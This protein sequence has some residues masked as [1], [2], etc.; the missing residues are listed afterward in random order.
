[1]TSTQQP[2]ELSE[3]ELRAY[4]D[5]LR[6]AEVG[7]ILVQAF[8]MLGTG[9]EVKLGR[10]DARVLID[11]MAAIVSAVGQRLGELGTR[12]HGGV[13]QLQMAQVEA[14]RQV[15]QRSAAPQADPAEQPAQQQQPDQGAADQ[16][17]MTD[18]LWIPGRGGGP[19]RS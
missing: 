17:K 1:V 2:G 9:A 5:Q 18:R 11:A 6:E 15:A 16:Q 10:P 12:M 3:E 14:E 8:T 13:T 19:P 4:L 7:D